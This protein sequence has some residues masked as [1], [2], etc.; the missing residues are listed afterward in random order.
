MD[1]N[2]VEESPK[3][4]GVTGGGGQRGNNWDNSNSIIN[5]IYFKNNKIKIKNIRSGEFLCIHF[6]IEDGRKCTIFL[7]YYYYFKER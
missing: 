5:K 4:R 7:A 6:N 2:Q 3:E 1:M